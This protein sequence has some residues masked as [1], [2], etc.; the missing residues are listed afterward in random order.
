MGSLLLALAKDP[1]RLRANLES[2]ALAEVVPSI[3]ED[4]RLLAHDREL[5]F[6]VSIGAPAVIEAPRQ[7]VQA[8]VGNLIRNAVENSERGSIRIR[9]E[10]SAVTVEDPGH[11]MTDEQISALYTQ[12][13]RKGETQGGGIGLDLVARLCDHLGW[14]LAMHSLPGKGTLAVLTFPP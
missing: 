5:T 2:I 6:E 8:A 1:S 13:A 9:V 4:H 3:V 12:L 11:G 7:M 10:A 14:S